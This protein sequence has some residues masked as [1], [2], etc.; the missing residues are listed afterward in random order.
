M[1]CILD[2]YLLR[3]CYTTDR[4]HNIRKMQSMSN[5]KEM[6][7]LVNNVTSVNVKFLMF[8]RTTSYTS[9]K[10]VSSRSCTTV[11]KSQKK[12]IHPR[13]VTPANSTIAKQITTRTSIRKNLV[14]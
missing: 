10:I 14:K 12:Q 6:I 1:I 3:I 2:C 13:K 9:R 4:H 7:M 8:T 11:I 5:N